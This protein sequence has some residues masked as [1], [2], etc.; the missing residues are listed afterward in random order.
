MVSSMPCTSTQ[1]FLG[2]V[3]ESNYFKK[4]NNYCYIQACTLPNSK[5]PKTPLHFYQ[6]AGYEALTDETQQLSD[7]STMA[8]ILMKK[9]LR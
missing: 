4:S 3:L 1:N 6:A 9:T 8:C 2:W 5:P 7:G